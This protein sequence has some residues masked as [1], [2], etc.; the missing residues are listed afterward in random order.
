M[1][2]HLFKT[3]AFVLLMA[4]LFSQASESKSSSQNGPIKPP[5][6]YHL[7]HNFGV[8]QI[9][10]SQETHWNLKA[11]NDTLLIKSI[12]VSG[13]DF[14][15]NTNCPNELPALEKCTV[16]VIFTPIT[17]GPHQGTVIVDLYSEM[18]IFELTGQGSL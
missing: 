10:N 7:A 3:I 16:G 4:P 5:K 13:E 2:L 1:S 11:K 15:L 14:K 18:F 17:E 6:E 12:T 9:N 8:V